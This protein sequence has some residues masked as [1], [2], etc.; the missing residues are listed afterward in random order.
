M[1]LAVVLVLGRV[2]EREP[3]PQPEVAQRQVD[4]A[5]LRRRRH[6]EVQAAPG[7]EVDG[8]EGARLELPFVRMSSITGRRS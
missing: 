4:K 2:H 1:G 3:V 5:V 7:A 6:G 8:V